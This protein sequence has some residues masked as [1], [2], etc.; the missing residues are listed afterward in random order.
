MQFPESWL[1]EFCNPPL[2][3][4]AAGRPADDGRPRGRGA[5]RRWRRRSPASSSPR[6]SRRRRTRNADRLRVCQVDAGAGEPLQ[7]V[8]GA[9]NAR[10]GHAACR[11]AL[12]GAELPPARTAAVQDRR[13]QAARR[14]VA[15][16]C[17]ARRA[18]WSSSED[19]GGLLELP[20]DAPVGRRHPRAACSST[21]R[22]FTLKLTPNRGA[23]R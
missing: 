19:H 21:T 17:C 3:T 7:I 18:N 10:A 8:C 14:R 16:A 5:A 23:L 9:P 2:D 1:R 13:R 12:V 11:C 15:A 22:V 6:S 4:A 20:A